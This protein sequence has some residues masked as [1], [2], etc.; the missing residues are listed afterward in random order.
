MRAKPSHGPWLWP[1][2][3]VIIGLILLLDNFLLLGDFDATLLWPLL[4]VL[5]GS[6]VLLRGDII[7]SSAGQTFGITRGSVESATLEANAGDVDVSIRPLQREGR[8][9]A[10]QF[11]A[12]SR[13]QLRVEDTHTHLRMNRSATPWYAFV[14]WDVGLARDLPWQVLVSTSI[15]QVNADLSSIITQDV[16]IA[17][18]F[19]DVRCVCPYEAFTPITL[20]S[21]LGN[22]QVIT[23]HGHAVRIIAPSTRFFKVHADTNR[24]EEMEEGVF[25]A[26]D[27]DPDAPLVEV[28]VS[29]TFGDAYLA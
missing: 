19:G 1:L 11:A 21:A 29:G 15:G 10:G 17:T 4:L 18:G 12:Q 2:L 13:P 27:A 9:I 23:P 22:I 3:L 8:L 20:H 6:A 7:P 24:Y 25:V 28:L 14:N 16:V 5:A 26:Y